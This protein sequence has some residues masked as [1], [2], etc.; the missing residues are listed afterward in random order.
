MTTII[1]FFGAPNSGKSV[2]A[3]KTFVDFKNLGLQCEL[4]TEY[5]KQWAWQNRPIGPYD[6]LYVVV[7]QMHRET[8]LLN[9]VEY[10]ITDSPVILGVFYDEFY[11]NG[12]QL[13]RPSIL[14]YLK[15]LEYNNVKSINYWL[16]YQG[17]YEP[18]GG[19]YH[20]QEDSKKINEK[21]KKW[22]SD[23]GVCFE[24][25]SHW[26]VNSDSSL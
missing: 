8:I 23:F 16:E 2:Q 3:S 7:N 14:Q 18:Q 21:M 5:I 25:K 20:N 13:A 19:R 4:V 17:G 9:K 24:T 11:N 1:N 10:I 26:D 12:Y 6:Q 22:F 15:L